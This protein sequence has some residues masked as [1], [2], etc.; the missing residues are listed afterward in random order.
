M[1]QRKKASKPAKP[2]KSAKSSTPKDDAK[3]GVVVDAF[4]R[5]PKLSAI[6]KDYLARL[7]QKDKPG[8]AFGS[9][10]LKAD[11]K[12]FAMCV[13][14]KLVVKLPKARVDELVTS[15]K[16]SYFDPGHGRLMKQW[17]SIDAPRLPWTELVREAY[18][19]VSGAGG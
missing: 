5:E 4:A 17:V 9:N 13:R 3:F 1:V 7:T 16:G 10:A 19:Y 2:A 18:T 6:A 11:G 8:R 15:G 12:I 14:G